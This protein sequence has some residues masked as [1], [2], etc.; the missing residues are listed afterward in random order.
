MFE[1]FNVEDMGVN[2]DIFFLLVI[3]KVIEIV[4]RKLSIVKDFEKEYL[5]VVKICYCKYVI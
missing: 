4:G 2:D 1:G 5:V 3:F